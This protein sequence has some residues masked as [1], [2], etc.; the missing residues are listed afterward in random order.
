MNLWVT[1]ENTTEIVLSESSSTG[2][3]GEVSY[4]L[5]ALQLCGIK[6]F[7]I[8]IFV[9]TCGSHNSPFTGNDRDC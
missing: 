5:I 3:T 6:A 2:C 9:Y 7:V 4:V 1:F 8:M